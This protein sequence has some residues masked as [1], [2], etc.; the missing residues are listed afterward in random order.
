M[1][2]NTLITDEIY[3]PVQCGQRRCEYSNQC[4]ASGAGFATL[5]CS[6]NKKPKTRVAD[7]KQVSLPSEQSKGVVG[8]VDLKQDEGFVTDQDK[9]KAQSRPGMCPSVR[10]GARCSKLLFC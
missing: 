7:S 5:D 4:F 8:S 6:K 1:L 10:R 9:A 3:Q 2:S